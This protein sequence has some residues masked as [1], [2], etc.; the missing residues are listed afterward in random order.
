M[1]SGGGGD[2]EQGVLAGRPPRGDGDEM[3]IGWPTDVRHVAHVTFDRFH[4]FRGIP[5]EL[6]LSSLR[7]VVDVVDDI[8]GVPSGGKTVFG[9]STESMQRPHLI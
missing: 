5:E 1:Q 8:A 7:A 3:E 6:L 4:G 9:V 2:E